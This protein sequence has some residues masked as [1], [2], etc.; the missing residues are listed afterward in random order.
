MTWDLQECR[1]CPDNN[2]S[3]ESICLSD[4]ISFSMEDAGMSKTNSEGERSVLAGRGERTRYKIITLDNEKANAK[5]KDG[6]TI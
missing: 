2:T 6:V 4:F 1:T 3:C 5:G